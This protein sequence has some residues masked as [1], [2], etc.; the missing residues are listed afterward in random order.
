[1]LRP[2]RSSQGHSTAV[3]KRP[4]CAVALRRTTW[5]DHGMGMAGKRHRHGHGMLCV[6][7]PLLTFSR[8]VRKI[9]KSDYYLCHV[10][11][12]FHWSLCLSVHMNQ[13]SFHWTDFHEISYLRISRKSVEKFHISLKSDKNS[14]ALHE[15][16]LTLMKISRHVLLRMINLSDKSCTENH[17]TRSIFYILY[18]FSEN[19][20]VGEICGKLWYSRTG[21]S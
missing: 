21:H 18:P 20:A 2:C 8:R 17:N 12:F 6:N 15:R 9:E 11:L 13:L 10:C 5:S 3:E 7:R 16:L 4:C 1:M 14:S 19:R